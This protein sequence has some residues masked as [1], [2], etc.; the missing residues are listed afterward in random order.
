MSL[1]SSDISLF[2]GCKGV[3]D[4]IL[5]IARTCSWD[6]WT[7]ARLQTAAYW[8]WDNGPKQNKPKYT[9]AI[10]DFFAVRLD[11]S[12]GNNETLVAGFTQF[13]GNL[14]DQGKCVL[15]QAI[16]LP[17]TVSDSILII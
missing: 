16:C 14:P 11:Q 5:L 15:Q 17:L 9:L 10:F 8:E 6:R 7:S 3:K 1:Q 2:I 4:T 13:G 12:G